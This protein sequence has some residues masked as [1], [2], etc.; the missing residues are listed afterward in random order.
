LAFAVE[1]RGMTNFTALS[2]TQGASDVAFF[3]KA[4]NNWA[5]IAALAGILLLST[6]GF[7]Y[8]KR[9]EQR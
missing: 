5:M 9:K 3:T 7:F 4:E 2:L 8:F 6:A 1:K